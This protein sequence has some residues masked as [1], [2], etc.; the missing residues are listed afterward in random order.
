M[1]YK[2]VWFLQKDW[3][4]GMEDLTKASGKVTEQQ[5]FHLASGGDHEVLGI[6]P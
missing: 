2:G 4:N 6:G 5:L 3:G 1:S